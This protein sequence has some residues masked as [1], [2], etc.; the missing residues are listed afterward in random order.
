MSTH[1][2]KPSQIIQ[3]YFFGDSVK[4]T[5]CLWLKNLP[6]LLPTEIIPPDITTLSTGAKFSTWDYK[7][8]MNHKERSKLRSKT[9]PGI[10]RA[11]A[12]Q[13]G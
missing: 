9:F 11:M 2:K 6:L 1:F 5:T 7:I 13:W 8:S 4:K 3:P 10:A 12:E